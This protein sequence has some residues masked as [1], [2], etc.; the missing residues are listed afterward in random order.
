[1][2]T[3]DSNTIVILVYDT[4]IAKLDILDENVKLILKNKNVKA[5]VFI[6]QIFS[7]EDEFVYSTDIKKIEDLLDSKSKREFKVDFNNCSNL[8]EKLLKKGFDIDRIWSRNPDR[9]FSKYSNSFYKI[10]KRH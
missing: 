10:K 8:L 2:R 9:L 5:I 3:L 1:M 7:I 4:D 6:P